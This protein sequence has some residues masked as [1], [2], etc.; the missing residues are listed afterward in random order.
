M[1]RN[2]TF[3]VILVL[4][5]QISVAQDKLKSMPGMNVIRK[6]HLKSARP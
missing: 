5:F 2:F 3:L 1:K 4:T 6:S